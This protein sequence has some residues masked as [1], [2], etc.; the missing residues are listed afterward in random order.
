MCNNTCSSL[1][2]P[3]PVSTSKV[4]VVVMGSVGADWMIAEW[5]GPHISSPNHHQPSKA[6]YDGQSIPNHLPHKCLVD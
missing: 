1:Q 5:D 4:V 6:G 2:P 3:C